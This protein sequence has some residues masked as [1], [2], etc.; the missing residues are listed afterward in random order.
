MMT[1]KVTALEV[2]SSPHRTPNAELVAHIALA[3]V[4][5]AEADLEAIENEYQELEN[6]EELRWY[7]PAPVRALLAYKLGKYEQG[8]KD[9]EEAMERYRTAGYRPL[10]AWA[11]YQYSVACGEAGTESPAFVRSLEDD[12]LEIGR[13][14]G[15]RALVQKVLGRREILKA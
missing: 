8:Q 7:H 9:F 2:L 4:A 15:M 10:L 14:L 3:Q 6:A 12:A 13:S 1:G 11:A 5:L